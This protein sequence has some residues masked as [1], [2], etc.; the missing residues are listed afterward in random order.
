[1]LMELDYFTETGNHLDVVNITLCAGSRDDDGGVPGCNWNGDGFRV[2][3]RSVDSRNENLR[4]R[5]AVSEDT[6]PSVPSDPSCGHPC[7]ICSIKK[8]L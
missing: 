8:S 6:L 4:V 2:Y 3:W 5:E 7:V 1:M